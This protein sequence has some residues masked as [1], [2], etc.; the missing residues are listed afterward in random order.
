MSNG[1]VR[2]KAYEE[3]ANIITNNPPRIKYPNRD[4]T[5]LFNSYPVQQFLGDG[6]ASVEF[7][8][9]QTIKC[10]NKN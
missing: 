8:E 9:R 5:G 4:A 6:S 7:L 3:I 2:R 10:L 1:L